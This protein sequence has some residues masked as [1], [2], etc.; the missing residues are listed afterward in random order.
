MPTLNQVRTKVDNWA[1]TAW[2]DFIVPRQELYFAAHGHYFQGLV[3]H[4]RIPSADLL[5]Y[6]PEL[7]DQLDLSPTDQPTTWNDMFPEVDVPLDFALK[8]DVYDGPL[9]SGYWVTL[10]VGYQGDV[11][12]RVKGHGPED[13]DAGWSL[14][15]DVILP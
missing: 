11:Y 14:V 2:T 4:T 13:H 3:T 8:C 9:G 7:G 1:A 6:H 10:Y 5:V 15:V 12:K